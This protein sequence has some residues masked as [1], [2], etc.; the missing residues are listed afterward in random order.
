MT[1][2]TGGCPETEQPRATRLAAAARGYRAM[3]GWSADVV[4]DVVMLQVTGRV[5]GVTVAPKWGGILAARLQEVGGHGPVLAPAGSGCWV[6]LADPNGVVVPRLP[7]PPGSRV[8]TGRDV[9]PLPAGAGLP[10]LSRWVVPPKA[11]DWLPLLET[12]LAKLSEM[13]RLGEEFRS[14][15]S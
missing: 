15:A 11:G 7:I 10:G 4:D 6:F 2:A 13:Y 1:A 12:L 5:G 14:R 9:V 8:L 3:F